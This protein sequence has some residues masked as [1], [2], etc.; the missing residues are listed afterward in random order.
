M[1]R[2]AGRLLISTLLIVVAAGAVALAA[3]LTS[4]AGPVDQLTPP[5]ITPDGPIVTATKMTPGEH[6]ISD[7]SIENPNSEGAVASISGRISGGSRELFDVLSVTVTSK[8]TRQQWSGFLWELASQRE[9]G[10]WNAGEHQDFK[11]DLVLPSWAGNFYQSLG[12]EFALDF[13][14]ANSREPAD[15]TPPTTKILTKKP[16]KRR[17]GK[18]AKRNWIIRGT[19]TDDRSAI[20][21]VKLSVLRVTKRSRKTKQPIRC[22]SFV[23]KRKKFA[24]ASKRGCRTTWFSAYGKDKWNY[25]FPMKPLKTGLFLIMSRVTDTAGNIETAITVGNSGNSALFRVKKPTAK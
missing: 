1:R 11:I 23:P 8:Q 19:A 13:S 25:V 18:R 20:A 17:L 2:F 22:T 12:A 5:K 6:R 16:P 3:G 14:F 15:S 7:F 9:P 10:A 21:D 4:S 24:R